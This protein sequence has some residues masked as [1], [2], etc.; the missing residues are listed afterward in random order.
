MKLLIEDADIERLSRCVECFPIDGVSVG[1]ELDR[2][3]LNRIRELIGEDCEL[4]VPIQSL[5]AEEIVDEAQSLV[6]DLGSNTYVK[7]PVGTEGFKAMKMSAPLCR[8]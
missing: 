6:D 8:R 3:A 5:R 7:I 1:S 2:T 4:H